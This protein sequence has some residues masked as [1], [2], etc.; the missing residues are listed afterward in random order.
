M[1][2]EK[3][4]QRDRGESKA[5]AK[6]KPIVYVMFG[7]ISERELVDKRKHQEDGDEIDTGSEI[8]PGS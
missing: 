5:D 6:R 8:F 3:S 7:K 4:E 2:I 1:H